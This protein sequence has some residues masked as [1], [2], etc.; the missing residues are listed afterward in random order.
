MHDRGVF[1]SSMVFLVAN[2]EGLRCLHL[3]VGCMSDILLWNVFFS[4]G[5]GR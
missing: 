5:S 2:D 3:R 4:T 1:S